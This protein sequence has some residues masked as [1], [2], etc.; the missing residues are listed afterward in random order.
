MSEFGFRLSSSSS[1]ALVATFLSQFDSHPGPMSLR[2][3]FVSNVHTGNW[4]GAER[5]REGEAV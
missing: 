4:E 3:R 1:L 5:A 2:V